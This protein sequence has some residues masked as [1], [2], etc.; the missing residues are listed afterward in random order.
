MPIIIN[1]IFNCIYTKASNK[2]CLFDLCEK[3]IVDALPWCYI[4]LLGCGEMSVNPVRET[5][6][7]TSFN[8]CNYIILPNYFR[9]LLNLNVP[10][11]DRGTGKGQYLCP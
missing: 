10:V 2:F 3:R 6:Y 1:G 9:G 8:S 5:S 4:L 7:K 11:P